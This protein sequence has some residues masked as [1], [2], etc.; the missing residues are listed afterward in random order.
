M[1][2]KQKHNLFM[3]RILEDIYS[4]TFLSTILGFKGG[5]C[6]FIF[7]NLSRFSVDLDFDLFT[8]DEEIYKQVLEK[9]KII[10]EKY[11][12]VKDSA[13]KRYTIFTL[14]SYGKGEHTIKIEINTR[15]GASNIRDFYELREHLGI[16]MMIQKK[17]YMFAKKLSALVSRT[18]IAMR[19]VYD[20]WYFANN[21]WDIDSDIIETVT[22]KNA[23][24]YLG[25][26]TRLIE[27]I[28]DNEIL[29]GLAELL[30]TEKD[31]MWAKTNL[32][33]EVIFLL[34]NYQLALQK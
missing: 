27:G 30:Y 15:S 19:D 2:D 25:D 32:R 26:C 23:I 29:Q 18:D 4:D 10:A 34:K 17:D 21:N 9:I 22:G 13:I 14:L 8:Q 12:E 6:A 3:G 16:P 5:T 33:K 20:I 1:L 31:K 24:E 7:Y 28:K 11:G